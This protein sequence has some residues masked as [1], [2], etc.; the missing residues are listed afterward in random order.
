MKG[1][2]V[3]P[4]RLSAHLEDEHEHPGALLSPLTAD[5]L[6]ALHARTHTE[7]TADH[8]HEGEAP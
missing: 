8:D 1:W 6:R 2:P 4:F 5:D 3:D 7:G